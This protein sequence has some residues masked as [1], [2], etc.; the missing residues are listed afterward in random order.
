MREHFRR[1]LETQELVK[2]LEQLQP[3][4]LMHY[5]NLAQACGAR[6]YGNSSALRS[7]RRIVQNERGWVLVAEPGTGVRRLSDAQIIEQTAQPRMRINRMARRAAR[8]LA[9]VEN[10]AALSPEAQRVH[11]VH[12]IVY[13][14]VSDNTAT[15]TI[16]R[17]VASPASDAAAVIAALKKDAP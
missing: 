15:K 14:H 5:A 2:Q 12:A 6:V 3:G 17:L 4:Q 9:A 8:N 13:A 7:A 1:S 16:A 11:Q 10:F